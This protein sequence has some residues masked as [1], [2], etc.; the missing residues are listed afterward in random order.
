MAKVTFGA[1]I[2]EARGKIGGVMFS[3][4]RGGNMARALQLTNLTAG[5]NITITGIWP[6]QTIALKSPITG[7]ISLTVGITGTGALLFAAGG[8]DQNVALTPSGTGFVVLGNPAGYGRVQIAGAAAT[9]RF[10]QFLTGPSL[11]WTLITDATAESGA[12]AG[13]NLGIN[14]YND[15]GAW[16]GY[17]FFIRRSDGQVG[18]GNIT[19]AKKLD[20]TGDVRAS[21]QL[22]S[23]VAIGT[24]PLDVTSTTEVPKLNAGRVGGT[25]PT[26]AAADGQLLIG[27]GAGTAAWG[28]PDGARVYNN[29]DQTIPNAAST[30]LTF[31]SERYDNGG[32]HSTA[33]NTSRLTAQRAGVYLITAT[34]EFDFHATGVRSLAILQNAFTYLAIEMRNACTA[35]PERMTITTLFHLAANDYVE[36]EAYQNSGGDLDVPSAAASSPEFAMQWLGP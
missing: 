19:P 10:L 14:R 15:A 16:S 2:S 8:A 5:A 32:L 9:V 21:L 23:T 6:N 1:G 28:T 22:I 31:N 30:I 12:N 13:S 29:A 34:A 18:I 26:N 24:P 25:E 4:T 11:R 33:S 35:A 20:V 27:S 17:A 3:R 36:L 7:P